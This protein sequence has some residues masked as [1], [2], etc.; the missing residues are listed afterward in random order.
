MDYEEWMYGYALRPKTIKQR[1]EFA[2]WRLREWGTWDQRPSVI[3]AWLGTYTGWTALT[4]HSHLS[5]IY[6]WQVEQGLLE[7]NPMA[8]VRRPP[9][10][11]PKPR[12]LSPSQ[13]VA[14]LDGTQGHLRSWMLLALLAGLR[15]HEIAK[16][17]GE[18]IDQ[19]SIFVDGKGGKEALL[20]S[21]PDLWHL[22]QEYPR[23]GFWFPSPVRP[24]ETYSPD[25][26]SGQIA[27]RF[28]A[29]GIERGSIHRLRA[30]FGTNLLRS[31]VNIRVV[32]KL[33]RHSSLA[34]TEHYLGVDDNELVAAINMLA[35]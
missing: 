31:G 13:V 30:T 27:D 26:V 25:H 16:F 24:G 22:A 21:H 34:A 28:R 33:M 1:V 18:D 17:R 11:E 12:P 5:S 29:V 35:A 19:T 32:Q 9:T 10:P 7:T 20:P 3:G 14:V 2:Q 6:K 15:R 23:K 4:Y 8:T